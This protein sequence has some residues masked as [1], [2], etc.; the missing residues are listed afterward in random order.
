MM[1]TTDKIDKAIRILEDA[2]ATLLSDDQQHR[3]LLNRRV[4]V[5]VGHSRPKDLGAL[6]ADGQT[7]EHGWNIVVGRHLVEHL[8]ALGCE[9]L[10]L[11][12]YGEAHHSYLSYGAA[13]D[14]AASRISSFMAECCVELHFN[15]AAHQASGFETLV[16]TS[17]KGKQL[18]GCLQSEMEK[19]FVGEHN[20]GVKIRQRN[21]RGSGWLYKTPCPAAIVEP[22]F[23]SNIDSWNRYKNKREEIAE[24]YCR[25]LTNYLQG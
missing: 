23:A 22:F 16:A 9:V 15:A 8:E 20:R 7:Y 11:Y 17:E 24:A 19:L 25:A 3:P 5:A 4:C 14:W 12:Q 2:K 1:K 18:G 10:F 21:E 6:A 13:I